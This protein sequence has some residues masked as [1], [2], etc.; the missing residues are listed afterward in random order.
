MNEWQENSK[1]NY[2]YVIEADDL[3]SVFK[4]RDGEWAGAY[5]NRFTKGTFVSAEKAMRAMEP[6]LDGELSMLKPP[7]ERGWLRNKG[8]SGFH[9][10]TPDGILS[11]KESKTGKWYA[12]IFGNL[13]KNHWFDTAQAAK[14]EVDRRLPLNRTVC[15]RNGLELLLKEL[16]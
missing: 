3:M 4:N 6:I 9:R 11:V 8:G 14:A 15:N 13:L 7:I 16:D 10:L 12:T 5:Q 1:G 2:V